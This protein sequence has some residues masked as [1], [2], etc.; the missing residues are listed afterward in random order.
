MDSDMLG[1]LLRI[2]AFVLVVTVLPVVLSTWRKLERDETLHAGLDAI[3][4]QTG[5]R[6]HTEPRTGATQGPIEPEALVARIDSLAG[7]LDRVP[8]PAGA[9]A[10]RS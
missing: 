8:E 4:Q 9:R 7:F 5:G 10:G 3:D 2:G 1:F 6:V